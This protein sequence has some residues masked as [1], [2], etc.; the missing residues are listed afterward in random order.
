MLLTAERPF[1]N[2]KEHLIITLK[3]DSLKKKKQLSKLKGH[4]VKKI[5]IA[6]I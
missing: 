2:Q 1:L 3:N 6:P 4:V 5:K